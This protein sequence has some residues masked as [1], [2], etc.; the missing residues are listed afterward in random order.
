MAKIKVFVSLK[1]GILD[2]QGKAVEAALGHLGYDDVSNVRIG[3]YIT[4]EIK[5]KSK[6][7]MD[8]QIK[9]MS[10]KL[11]AN[12]VIEDFTYKIEKT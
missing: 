12:T 4:F 1:K 8:K 10:K 5:N 2:P 7:K 6:D 3:K 9:D 11:L